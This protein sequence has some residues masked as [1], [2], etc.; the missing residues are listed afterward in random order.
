MLKIMAF[1]MSPPVL[2]PPQPT[3]S[4]PNRLHSRLVVNVGFMSDGRPGLIG[5]PGVR[6][7]QGERGSKGALGSPGPIGPQGL[8]GQPGSCS[9]CQ[10]NAHKPQR[11]KSPSHVPPSAIEHEISELGYGDEVSRQPRPQSPQPPA[12]TR[13]P[14]VQKKPPSPPAIAVPTPA[15]YQLPSPSPYA[16]VIEPVDTPLVSEPTYNAD[17]SA[18]FVPEVT[19]PEPVSYQP[20]PPA[21]YAILPSST[22][23]PAVVTESYVSVKPT[24]VE[25]SPYTSAPSYGDQPNEP[26]NSEPVQPRQS[27]GYSDDELTIMSPVRA[28]SQRVVKFDRP[29][30]IRT[31]QGYNVQLVPSSYG[32]NPVGKLWDAGT[33]TK[34]NP[35]HYQQLAPPAP[36]KMSRGRHESVGEQTAKSRDMDHR[37]PSAEVDSDQFLK[38]VTWQESVPDQQSPTQTSSVDITGTV[39]S[40]YRRLSR[41]TLFIGLLVLLTVLFIIAIVITLVVVFALKGD[42]HDHGFTAVVFTIPTTSSPTPTPFPFPV[43]YVVGTSSRYVPLGFVSSLMPDTRAFAFRHQLLSY[44]NGSLHLINNNTILEATV[45]LNTSNCSSC[46]IMAAD[47]YCFSAASNGCHQAQVIYC[48]TNCSYGT[49]FCRVKGVLYAVRRFR[50]LESGTTGH[51]RGFQLLILKL[52]FSDQLVEARVYSDTNGLQLTTAS[53]ISS[54]SCAVQTHRIG[55]DGSTFSGSIQSCRTMQNNSSEVKYAY[56]SSTTL[57]PD[58]AISADILTVIDADG[59]VQLTQVSTG[60]VLTYLPMKIKDGHLLVAILQASRFYLLRY[61]LST[62]CVAVLD[63]YYQTFLF[64]GEL[65]NFAWAGDS[66]MLWYVD[67]GGVNVV[68]FQFKW[69]DRC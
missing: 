56:L 40:W 17:S 42:H 52:Q 49:N 29:T 20:P 57:N 60:A 8:I 18:E 13:S 43:G 69:D 32:A 67:R 50:F 37:F 48:C 61:T 1:V 19:T 6:G 9:H 28:Y 33:P 22:E 30:I 34:Y 46:S 35:A 51:Q 55:A 41:R 11:P 23:S 44:G 54:P 24:Q 64:S 7:P 65:R 26:A 39:R 12:P 14:V 38:I 21:S 63:N 47:D 59:G 31:K 58:S 53:Q 16:E 27:V 4:D 10:V 25:A 5:S 66:L 3:E 45:L 68:Q 36:R 62:K 2:L 15:S